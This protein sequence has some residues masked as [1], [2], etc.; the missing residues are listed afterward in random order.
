[1]TDDLELVRRLSVLVE[2]VHAVV[3][4]AS[5]PAA[6]YAELGLRGYFASR[7]AAL[8]QA[9]PELVT[10]L[11]GGCAPDM[12]SRAV[13]QVWSIATP[14]QVQAALLPGVGCGVASAPRRGLAAAG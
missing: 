9:G 5:E 7:A 13:P 8:G 1:M 6:A 4:F 14:G 2:S 10:A 11:F 12:V 3:Y